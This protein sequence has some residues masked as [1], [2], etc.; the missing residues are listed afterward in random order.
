ME[1]QKFPIAI[2]TLRLSAFANPQEAFL[3][4]RAQLGRALL[5]QGVQLFTDR[6]GQP[7]DGQFRI[8]VRAANRRE[9]RRSTGRYSIVPGDKVEV[10]I[11]PVGR[12][13]NRI[14]DEA[15]GPG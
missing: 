15:A 1:Q 4:Q 5:G 9:G 12:L 2:Q 3:A 10:D 14:I 11:G 13:V 6:L 8:A 7:A